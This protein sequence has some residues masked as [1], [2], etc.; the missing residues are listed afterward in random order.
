MEKKIRG[1][2]IWKTRSTAMW[3]TTEPKA[4]MPTAQPRFAF[5]WARAMVSGSAC[6]VERACL[7]SP[8]EIRPVNTAATMI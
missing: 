4:T 1:W 2:P 5:T 6:S 7:R 8:Y 3:A